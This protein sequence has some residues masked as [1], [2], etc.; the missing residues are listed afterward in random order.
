MSY[1]IETLIL[2]KIYVGL[3]PIANFEGNTGTKLVL[4]VHMININV[5]IMFF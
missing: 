2:I 5:M 3:I 4:F 1:V